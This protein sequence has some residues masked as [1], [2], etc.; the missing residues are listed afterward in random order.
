M[1]TVA[2]VACLV[3]AGVLVVAGSARMLSARMA[4]RWRQTRGTVG[5]VLRTL[6][7][8]TVVITGG[9]WAVVATVHDWRVVLAVLATPALFAA[10]TVA[11]LATAVATP[12]IGM[13]GRWGDLR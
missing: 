10:G 8:A 12:G 6:A 9:Q 13:A 5:R 11:R 3:M 4:L 7:V 2:V 1:I